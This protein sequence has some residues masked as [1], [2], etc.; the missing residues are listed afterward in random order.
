MSKTTRLGPFNEPQIN[1][2]KAKLDQQKFE[3]KIEI[4]QDLAKK[5][6]DEIASKNYHERYQNPVSPLG[7]FMFIEVNQESLILIKKYLYDLGIVVDNEAEYL[8]DN[9][10]Y[11][12]I[13]DFSSTETQLCPTD[14]VKLVDYYQSIQIK[15]ENAANNPANK[16][17]RYAFIAFVCFVVFVLTKEG[18]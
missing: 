7:E 8:P 9:E 18:F 10:L 5:Y 13:C 17:F 16:F 12:T 14:G 3:Y 4:D 6:Q 15:K 1:E 11:C 2:I